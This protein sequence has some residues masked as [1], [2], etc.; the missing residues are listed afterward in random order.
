MNADPRNQA[1]KPPPTLPEV[2]SATVLLRGQP[3]LRIEHGGER[4]QLR[5]TK[6]GKLILTK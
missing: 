2:V 6:N 4:Y 3:V 1:V 5:L